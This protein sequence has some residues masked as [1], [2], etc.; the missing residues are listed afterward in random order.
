MGIYEIHPLFMLL[1]IE[2]PQMIGNKLEQSI[3]SVFQNAPDKTYSINELAKILNKA[4]PYINHKTRFFLREKIL[5]K[6][7]IGRSYQCY[8][9]LKN[10]KTLVYL[11]INEVNNREKYLKDNKESTKLLNI[12]GQQGYITNI[13][14]IVLHDDNLIIIIGENQ[15]SDGLYHKGRNSAEEISR[16]KD[17]IR[18]QW[19]KYDYKIEI[20]NPEEFRM[21]LLNHIELLKDHV[22]LYGID[23]Y[24]HIVSGCAEE[25]M[26]KGI[27]KTLNRSDNEI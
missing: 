18:N 12:L 27:L 26:S 4:Y 14:T 9:N 6:L 24:L 8:L 22:T 10:E 17:N 16:L 13:S 19:K 1:D 5:K 3:I 15:Y 25:I 2:G 20:M 11:K 23:S 21:Y 7:D